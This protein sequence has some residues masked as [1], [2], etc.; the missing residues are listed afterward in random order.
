MNTTDQESRVRE[1]YATA[2]LAMRMRQSKIGSVLMLILVPAGIVLDYFVYPEHLPDFTLM[3]LLCDT[4]IAVILALHFAPQGQRFV[5]VLTLSWLMAAVVMISY[6]IHVTEGAAS[7]YYAGISLTIVAIGILLPL[8][9]AEVVGFCVVSIGIY[10][11]ACYSRGGPIVDVSEFFNNIYFLV[12]ASIISTTAVF[13]TNRRR[14]NEFRLGFELE[15]NYEALSKLDKMKS[16]FFANISHELRTPLGLILA[17]LQDLQQH[18]DLKPEVQKFLTTANQNGMRLLRL[19]NDL[20]ELI[21]LEEGKQNLEL[22][23]LKINQ[24]LDSQID[25]VSHYTQLKGISVRKRLCKEDA[26]VLGDQ[27]A[28]ERIFINL[29]GNASKFTEGGG[30]IWISS[31]IRGDDLLIEIRDTGVGIP[32]AELSSIFDRFHQVDASSTRRHQGTG[33]GLALVKEL[34]EKQGGSIGVE[35][36]LGQGTTMRLRFPLAK[37][38]L[39]EEMSEHRAQPLD[40]LEKLNRDAQRALPGGLDN[41]NNEDK[42]VEAALNTLPT[43]MIVDDEPGMRSYLVDLLKDSYH[44]IAVND[45][46]LALQT[47][48]A[49]KPELMLLDLMLPTMDGLEVCRKLKSDPETE[50]IKIVLLTARVD[51]SAKIEAL[52]NGANDFLTKPFSSIEIR[53][54]LQNLCDQ[55][56]LESEL[57]DSNKKLSSTLSL[58]H[59]AQAQMLHEKKLVALGSMAAGLLHEVQNPLSYTLAAL[60]MLKQEKAIQSSEDVIDMLKDVDEGI[61][62]VNRIVADLETF[63]YPSEVDKQNNFHF[64]EAIKLA[65]RFTRYDIAPITVEVQV[66]GDDLVF[67]SE[68]HIVQVLVNLLRNSGKVLKEQDDNDNPQL[69]VIVNEAGDCLRVRVWD[70]G[71][72]IAPDLQTRIFEPFFTTKDVGEG[73]GLGLS[74]CHTIIKN[75]NGELKVRSEPGEW[76]EFYFELPRAAASSEQ[77]ED[78]QDMQFA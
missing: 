41:V 54:R 68:G 37:V 78:E 33:I 69:K 36:E 51:E 35:S 10:T 46:H 63:A 28:F 24:L 14:L 59:Q 38:A 73:M 55:S 13:F 17:P 21:R 29:L 18:S 43:L 60:H 77:P 34:T 58:L 76:T 72:G 5:R 47:A 9:V 48:R 66:Q 45:G 32:R 52:K 15:Q 19:V 11:V 65:V 26:I 40:P 67:G 44:I 70:N 16:Q 74:I 30:T 4:F 25:A 64:R 50:R 6:M 7:T 62:R 31:E 8:T 1:A 42:P 61:Q 53:T 20:L 56:R 3:R 2:D 23:P 27:P 49:E 57:T 39:M 22:Q 12:L 71:P 75:H